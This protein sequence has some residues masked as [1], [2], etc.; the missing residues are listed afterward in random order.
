MKM[1]KVLVYT[2]WRRGLLTEEDLQT[3]FFK[4]FNSDKRKK[5]L[6]KRSMR[7]FIASLVIP[8]YK[9]LTEIDYYDTLNAI[10]R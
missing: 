7:S 10:V 5:N 2:K 9:G 6:L 4:N 8:L 1:R 3:K